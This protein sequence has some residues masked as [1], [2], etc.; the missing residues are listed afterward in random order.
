[1]ESLRQGDLGEMRPQ[2]RELMDYP[3]K[4]ERKPHNV[5]LA[6]ED[7]VRWTEFKFCLCS[8]LC[9]IPGVSRV[10]KEA[11]S[12]PPPHRPLFSAHHHLGIHGQVVCTS[13]SAH[14]TG[15]SHCP[16]GEQERGKSFQNALQHFTYTDLSSLPRD[17][18]DSIAHWM[19]CQYL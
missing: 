15:R 13:H 18:F 8:Q 1:M 3:V 19:P 14:I 17:T 11:F 5:R 6:K 12:S 10:G 2:M 7:G 4:E 16:S 9:E